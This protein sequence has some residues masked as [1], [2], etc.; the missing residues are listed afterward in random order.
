MGDAAGQS[1]HAFQFLRLTQ[2]LL[3]VPDGF[4]GRVFATLESITYSV[5]LV[6]MAAA[7]VASQYWDPLAIGAWAGALSSTTAISWGWMHFS[8]RLPEPAA[9]GIEPEEIEVHGE[10]TV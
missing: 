7:G 1:A 10:P 6:S 2:L 4:R 5:M 9:E 3:H 8:G